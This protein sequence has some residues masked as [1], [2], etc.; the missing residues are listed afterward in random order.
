M[1]GGN[2]NFEYMTVKRF[3]LTIIRGNLNAPTERRKV[4]MKK[5]EVCCLKF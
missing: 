1:C 5:N 2:Q 3:V 4:K